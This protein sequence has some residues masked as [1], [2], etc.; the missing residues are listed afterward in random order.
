[1]KGPGLGLWWAKLSQ[2]ERMGNKGKKK[3]PTGIQFWEWQ[4]RKNGGSQKKAGI[5][6]NKTFVL[7][8]DA[9][10]SD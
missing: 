10:L 2:V 1:M 6:Q 8:Y 5:M 3:I 4:E 7:P 9:Q